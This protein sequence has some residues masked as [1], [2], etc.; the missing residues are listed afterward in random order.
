MKITEL[1]FIFLKTQLLF[2]S[3]VRKVN[4]WV[5]ENNLVIASYYK[6]FFYMEIR[7]DIIFMYLLFPVLFEI[8]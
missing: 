4:G 6:Q 2:F 1:K 8:F 3:N 5:G 7:F